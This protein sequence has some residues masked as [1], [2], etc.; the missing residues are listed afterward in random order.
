[1]ITIKIKYT[2]QGKE[3]LTPLNKK[4]E[5]IG[6]LKIYYQDKLLDTQKIILKEN[7]NFNI[8]SF[9]KQEIIPI[10]SITSTILLVIIIIIVK[11]KRAN[12]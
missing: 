4:G 11:K 2:Y 8:Q 1:M 3:E 10:I 12:H 6:T 9:L 7:L 5:T